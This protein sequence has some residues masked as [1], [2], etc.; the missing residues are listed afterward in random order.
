MEIIIQNAQVLASRISYISSLIS[1]GIKGGAVV[2]TLG[3]ESKSRDQERKY[4]A[5]ITDIMRTVR[6]DKPHSFEAWKALLVDAYAAELMSN[7]EKLTH[8]GE[9]VISFDGLRAVT[10]RPSTKKFSK[11]EASGFIEFLYCWGVENGAKFSEK[12]LE[13]AGHK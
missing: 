4:H 3:R 7:G 11:K 8:P 5:M 13:I 9:T 1:R 10:V 2:V 6:T 12:S